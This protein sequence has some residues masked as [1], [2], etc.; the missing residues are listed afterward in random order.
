[1]ESQL[2]VEPTFFFSYWGLSWIKPWPGLGMYVHMSALG[3]AAV[4]LMVGFHHRVAAAA[5]WLLFTYVELLDKSAYLNHY[6]LASLILALMVFMPL[7]RGWSVDDARRPDVGKPT[8][9]RWCL[10]TLRLQFG[11][12]YFY[13]GVAKLGSDWLLSAQPLKTWFVANADAPFVGP[14]LA[15][16]WVAHAASWFG[17]IFDLTLPFWLSWPRSRS[18]AFV[19]ALIFHAT[20]AALFQLGMFPFIMMA[21]A[22]LFFD[23]DWP[24]RLGKG[25]YGDSTPATPPRAPAPPLPRWTFVLIAA[26]FAIQAIVPLRHFAYPQD[27]LWTEEGFRFAWRV[28]L[29]EKAGYVVFHVVDP[30]TERRW[31]VYPRDYLTP[32][33]QKVFATQPDMILQLAHHV[34]DDFR[35][36]GRGNVEVRAEAYVAMNGRRSAMLI[37][38]EVDL[39]REHDG[40]VPKPWILPNALSPRSHRGGS[41]DDLSSPIKSSR[42]DNG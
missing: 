16:P 18:Y 1:M 7:G 15:L 4:A 24:R 30:D 10:W 19:V 40:F 39:A 37:D 29:V 20:T 9:P 17:A 27:T 8:V 41:T 11:L 31:L 21:G 25:R 14:L 12:V 36:R 2:Y 28:M 33:Q 22:T 3:L 38:P 23:P 6:Y 42:T 13:A 34:A 35:A 5:A 26:H 32:L